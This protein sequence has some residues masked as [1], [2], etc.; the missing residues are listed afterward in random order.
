M[1]LAAELLVKIVRPLPREAYDPL[2][3]Y[4]AV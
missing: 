1:V 3:T 4:S 2:P